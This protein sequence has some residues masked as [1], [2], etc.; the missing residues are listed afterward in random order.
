MAG[1]PYRA[2]R[3]AAKPAV[4]AEPD[5]QP[6]QQ[7]DPAPGNGLPV[8]G[9]A[10]P[11]RPSLRV[12]AVND[13]AELEAESVAELVVDVL[14]RAPE[15]G[16]HVPAEQLPADALPSGP[17]HRAPVAAAPVGAEGGALDETAASD[18]EGLRGGGRPLPD[19][20]RRSMESAFGTDLAGVRVH[21]GPTASRLSDQLGAHAFTTGNDIV[22]ADGL[23][24]V[25]QP[26]GQRLMAHELTHVLQHRGAETLSALRRQAAAV[27]RHTTPAEPVRLQL[28][29][30]SFVSGPQA[31][32]AEEA[33]AIRRVFE[34]AVSPKAGPN[35]VIYIGS[36][37]IS[38]RPKNPDT[39]E[40]TQHGGKSFHH[41]SAW[42]WVER[43]VTQ[44]EG[45]PLQ[46][47]VSYLVK[48]GI[49]PTMPK[50]P[51]PG[52][53]MMK[54]MIALNGY[55][56]NFLVTKA[57]QAEGWLGPKG[58]HSSQGGKISGAI[59]SLQSS[60]WS[61][62]NIFKALTVSFEPG[63]EVTDKALWL[64]A[65]SHAD[66]FYA[67]NQLMLEKEGPTATIDLDEHAEIVEIIYD[68]D[69]QFWKEEYD[70][71]HDVEMAEQD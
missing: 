21:T 56:H 34:V 65:Q 39:S 30:L 57:Q 49:D 9:L 45:M 53:D 54:Q 42:T 62:Q 68:W 69:T 66:A 70:E 41:E 40:M 10:L 16:A 71:S 12:G 17:I 25:S 23:P 38:D 1:M 24:D 5:R 19:G 47:V 58:T 13:P 50:L 8:A 67:A 11:V 52:G 61:K 64:A 18:V 20:I 43:Q 4:P 33:A 27:A 55:F 48:Y 46:E 26:D 59:K 15:D 2:K 6:E 3:A 44:F 22:F 28:D 7:P 31:E 51:D 60:G 63:P 14:R 35:D 36:V 32:P 37:V 29:T